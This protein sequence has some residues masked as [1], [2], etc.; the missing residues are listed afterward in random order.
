MHETVSSGG[1]TWTP[2]VFTA[3]VC[4]GLIP[5]QPGHSRQRACEPFR[6]R[7]LNETHDRLHG[8][9]ERGVSRE[10]EHGTEGSWNGGLKTDVAAYTHVIAGVWNR[11]SVVRVVVQD[12]ESPLGEFEVLCMS[13]ENPEK[14]IN[15]RPSSSCS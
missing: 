12:C 5:P 10:R 4:Q 3:D 11:T 15:Q 9:G 8:T 6:L 7:Q 2:L 14:Q 1:S 13:S